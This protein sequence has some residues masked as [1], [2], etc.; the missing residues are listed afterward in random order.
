MIENITELTNRLS[1]AQKAE[2]VVE[3]QVSNQK[4]INAAKEMAVDTTAAETKKSNSRGVVAA[5]TAEAATAAGKSVAGIP[6]VGIAMAAAAVAG[7]IALFATLPKFAKGG[8]IGGGPS[9]GDKILA[10]VNAGEMILNQG[11]QSNLF[12]A[13]NSGKLG[14]ANNSS[15]SSTVTTKVRAKDIILAINNELKSQGKKTIS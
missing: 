4:I 8:I 1:A 10:R 5:N 6:F 13:I 2:S 12:K 15:L 14:N 11:Q 9:S 7:I 3:Q